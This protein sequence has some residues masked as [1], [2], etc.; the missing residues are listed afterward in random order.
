MDTKQDPYVCCLQEAHFRSRD[1]YRLKVRGWKKIVVDIQLLNDVWLFG[2][3][4][5]TARQAPLSSTI[6][7]SLLKFLSTKSMLLPN[8]LI[9]CH[10]PSHFAFNLSQHQGL[11]QWVGWLYQVA[12]IL[13]LQH[14]SFQWIFRVDFLYDWLVWSPCNQRDSQESSP[15]P[16]FKS[17][18]SSA[19]SLLYGPTLTSVPDYWK[20]H[21]FDPMDLCWQSGV[22]VFKYAV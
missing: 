2:T 15:A 14:Q 18:N 8:Q 22:S 10:S 1:T 7:R 17:I 5:T 20:N 13:E 16:Q 3:P 6:S 11:S 4:W 21:T 9:L 19:L 12:K